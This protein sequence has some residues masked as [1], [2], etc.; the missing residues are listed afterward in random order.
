M[1]T[2][3]VLPKS[4]YIELKKRAIEKGRTV[5]EV[6]IDAI[7]NYLSSKRSGRRDW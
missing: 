4:V 1:K 5:R 6:L 3:F 7:L 2:S